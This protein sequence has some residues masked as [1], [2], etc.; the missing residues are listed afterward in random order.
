MRHATW[1][2]IESSPVALRL[3]RSYRKLPAAVRTPLRWITMPRWYFAV[4]YIRRV[5]K[6]RVLSGPF[7]GLQL[8]LSPVS[9][10]HLLG[11][12]LGTQE[13]ELCD[14]V[15][16]IVSRR[17]S[18]I[19]NIG[20]ADGYYAIGLARRLPEATVVGFEALPEHHPPLKRA[21]DA[22]GVSRRFRLQGFCDVADLRHELHAACHP[23]LVIADIEGGEKHLLDPEKVE[24]LRRVD[25]LIETHDALSPGCTNTLIERFGRTHMIEHIISRPRTLSDFPS[26]TL[27]ALARLMPR[28]A[29]ELMNERRKGGQDWLFLTTKEPFGKS[30]RCRS[31]P[32]RKKN[33]SADEMVSARRHTRSKK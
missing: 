8:E 15:E 10:R 32:G 25:M 23:V 29:V 22:N 16:R 19:V 14:I 28:M 12:L 17:Y 7:A 4:A 33:G 11:Y 13:M 30:E 18:T 9:G 2:A 20:A 6:N 27:P 26:A 5:A 31:S 3:Y 1:T 21:A 24:A